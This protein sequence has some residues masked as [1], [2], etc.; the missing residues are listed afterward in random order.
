MSQPIELVEKGSQTGLSRRE[1]VRQTGAGFIALAAVG[2]G[3]ANLLRQ[4]PPQ[5]LALS[6]GVIMPNPSLCIGCLTCEVA[7]SQAHR[8]QGLSDVP[9][10]RIFNDEATVLSQGLL[11]AYGDRG[12]FHQSPCL[13]CPD[14]PCHYVCPADALPIEPNSGVRHIDE[15]KCI[16]CGRCA[17]ACPF[18][19]FPESE[20][21]NHEALGQ[22]TRI[23]YDPA[24]DVYTKCDLCYWRPEG[25]ACAER[26][27]VNIRIRQGL[28]DSDVMC[29]DV[30]AA[31]REHWEEQQALEEKI[32]A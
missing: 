27:P 29:L 12:H 28:I 19:V 16:A 2:L 24:K 14:A 21:T 7:C 5:A 20:A 31:T 4:S 15:S 30:P 26:C 25:P 10:I 32:R 8:E 13:M 18:P 6:S 3:G 22:R 1:F 11:D 9:R 23:T 17:T